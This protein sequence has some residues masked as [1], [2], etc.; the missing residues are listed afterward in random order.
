MFCREGEGAVSFSVFVQACRVRRFGQDFV[1]VTGSRSAPAGCELVEIHGEHDAERFLRDLCREHDNLRALEELANQS[2][3]GRSAVAGGAAA[4]IDFDFDIDFAGYGPAML[5]SSIKGAKRDE[6]LIY[7]RTA[8]TPSQNAQAQSGAE[9]CGKPIVNIVAY[10]VK[11]GDTLDAIAIGYGITRDDLTMFNFGTTDQKEIDERL[12]R[13]VGSRRD[14]KTGCV[15]LCSDD[16]PGVIYVPKPLRLQ[17]LRLDTL[18]IV[19]VARAK[20]PKIFPMSV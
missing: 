3:L 12:R 9:L 5:T 2:L 8:A 15:E 16:E 20:E 18:H 14:S 10:R 13:D 1:L 7:V 4:T 6:A 17:G 19:R 11:T